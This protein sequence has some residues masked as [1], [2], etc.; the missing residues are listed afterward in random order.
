MGVAA[1]LA[2]DAP[3]PVINA[4]PTI[5][6]VIRN[7][8]FGDYGQMIV[9]S[10]LGAVLGFAGGALPAEKICGESPRAP[11]LSA[12]TACCRRAAGKPIRRQGFFYMGGLVGMLCFTQSFRAS[13]FRLT[14]QRPNESE[15]ERKGIAF[16]SKDP[17]YGTN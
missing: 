17:Y 1:P 11:G 2:F 13:Y 16:Y 5:M 9:G 10:G 8:Y 15:C 14:G 7:F 4:Q 12:R 3:Y 6:A